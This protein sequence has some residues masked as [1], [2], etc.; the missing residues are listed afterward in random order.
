MAE[1]NEILVHE[2]YR[3]FSV[4]KT[5]DGQWLLGRPKGSAIWWDKCE[6]CDLLN[7]GLRSDDLEGVV[8][9]HVYRARLTNI[10]WEQAEGLAV[11]A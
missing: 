2:S 9:D 6:L 10:L 5:S 4:Q 1:Q 8:V 11:P 7:L 3:G